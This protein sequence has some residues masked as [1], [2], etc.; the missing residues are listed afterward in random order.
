MAKIGFKGTL[1]DFFK[2]IKKITGYYDG[3]ESFL[4]LKA[5]VTM[6]KAIICKE[7]PNRSV[8]KTRH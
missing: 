3:I 1:N 6:I 8:R 5:Q 4:V 7:T 2:K